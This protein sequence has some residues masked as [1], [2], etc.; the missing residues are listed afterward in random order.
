MLSTGH[1]VPAAGY[2]VWG[3]TPEKK[4]EEE[5]MQGEPTNGKLLRQHLLKGIE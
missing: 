5:I 4:P 3:T 2:P 1:L